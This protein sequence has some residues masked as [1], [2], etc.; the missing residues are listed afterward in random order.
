V[1]IQVASG[2]LSKLLRRFENNVRE[3]VKDVASMRAD[4]KEMVVELLFASLKERLVT[5]SMEATEVEKT[6]AVQ[7]GDF[8]LADQLKAVIEQKAEEKKELALILEALGAQSNELLSLKS[9][10]AFCFEQV[11]KELRLFEEEQKRSM[12]EDNTKVCSLE[13]EQ[14]MLC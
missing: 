5:Q 12:E 8:G 11:E 7:E 9:R 4:Q 3:A 1:K 2:N 14:L 10:V 6:T 13:L